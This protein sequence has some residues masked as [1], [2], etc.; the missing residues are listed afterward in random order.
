MRRKARRDRNETTIVALARRLG[1]SVEYLDLKDGPD[2]VVGWQGQNWLIEVKRP[3]G[4]RG[5]ASEDGQRLSHGQERWHAAWKGKVAVV[6]TLEDLR[7]LLGV[8][9]GV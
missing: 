7:A 8:G 6:R 9:A 2:L 3:L 4:R 1:A 5:G